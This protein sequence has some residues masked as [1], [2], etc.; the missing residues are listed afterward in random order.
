MTQ[1]DM[2][3]SN[4]ESLGQKDYV[5]RDCG[6]TSATPAILEPSNVQGVSCLTHMLYFIIFFWL[7]LSWTIFL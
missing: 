2:A 7:V 5:N 4:R 3:I 1:H 6:A